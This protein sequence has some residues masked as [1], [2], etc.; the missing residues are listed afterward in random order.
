M[1]ATEELQLFS[2]FDERGFL[3]SIASRNVAGYATNA[4]KWRSKPAECTK[5]HSTQRQS[6][7]TT[8]AQLTL[9]T[10]FGAMPEIDDISRCH[11]PHITPAAV[12]AAALSY[13]SSPVRAF[14]R[15]TMGYR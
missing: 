12:A 13:A 8:A 1:R 5:W 10:A 4:A 3:C 7:P 14:S 11:I 2:S 9:I 6:T 15:L